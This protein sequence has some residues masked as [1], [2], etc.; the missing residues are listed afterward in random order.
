MA[1]QQKSKK[2]LASKFFEVKAPLTSSKIVLYGPTTESFQGRTVKLDL[3]RNLRGKN[4]ELLLRLSAKGDEIE[5]E[6]YA[7]QVFG[8]YIR[9]MLRPGTD[10]IEDSFQLECKDAVLQVKPFIIARKKVPRSL[11][12]SLRLEAQNYLK[13][14]FVPRTSLELFGDLMANK[15]QKDL[16]LKLKKIYPLAFCEIRIF[17]VIRKK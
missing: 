12:N 10:Y 15:I 9:R 4:V 16:S 13:S 3:T 7:L 2:K 1:E 6:P 8:S 11:R 14:A 5:G 17:K